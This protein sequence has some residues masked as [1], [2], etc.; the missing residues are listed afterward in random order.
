MIYF[1]GL[2]S[3]I[4]G[5]PFGFVFL[6]NFTHIKHLSS[7]VGQ[8]VMLSVD[9]VGFFGP[10]ANVLHDELDLA[11]SL[12]GNENQSTNLFS[13]I[14]DIRTYLKEHIRFN[15]VEDVIVIYEESFSEEASLIEKSLYEN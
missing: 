8:D 4:S 14:Y 3:N 13:S 12:F 5:R 11:A 9:E 10:N 2:S 1:E 7:I 15:R 6:T